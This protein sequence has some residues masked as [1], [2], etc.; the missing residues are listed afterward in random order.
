MS[1]SGFAQPEELSLPEGFI[2]LGDAYRLFHR[3][4]FHPLS[5]PEVVDDGNLISCSAALGAARAALTLIAIECFAALVVC[6]AWQLWR[7]LR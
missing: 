1:S 6:G 3:T 4:E 5:Q 7:I 2:P